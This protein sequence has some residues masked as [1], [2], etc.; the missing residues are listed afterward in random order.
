MPGAELRLLRKGIV[1]VLV[2][3]FFGITAYA[4]STVDHDRW[5]SRLEKG[6]YR[7]TD[8][9]SSSVFVIVAVDEELET[10]LPGVVIS[11]PIQIIA[12]TPDEVEDAENTGEETE[13]IEGDHNEEIDP[14]N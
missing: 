9:L 3:L 6:E 12:A 8:E 10:T 2:F 4:F 11:E 13:E 1:V 14:S 7:G 5:S